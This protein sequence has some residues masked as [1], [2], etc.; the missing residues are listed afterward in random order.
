MKI[1]V[2]GA[3]AYGLALSNILSDKNEILVYSSLKEEIEKLK[4][5][6][7]FEGIKLSEKINYTSKTEKLNN[8]DIAV[9]VLP[10]Q[11]IKSELNKLKEYIKNK[12][13]IVASK[14]I[15]ENKFASE[16]VEES[17]NIESTHVLSGPSFAIDTIK[18]QP[19]VLTLAGN[20][21]SEIKNI[22]NEGY[23]KIEQTT[24]I[25]GTQI[26]GTVKNTFA[27]G[28]GILEGINA[29]T[30]TKA[31]YMTKIINETKTII[32]LF[33]GKEDT[34]MLSCG[35]GDIILTC[36]STK[37]RNFTL[38]YMKGKNENIKEYIKMQTVEGIE[39]LK[40]FSKHLNNINIEM[41]NV[42]Y[43][44]IYDNANCQEIL[45]YIIK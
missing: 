32:K 14:G 10:T 44:I 8:I 35:I 12:P 7:S 13:I 19:I 21:T 3:G 27:I 31:A 24:D 29:T 39:S 22:F 30:S 34:I 38:G 23:V 5:T 36:T 45:S 43:R 1:L 40:Y 11:F 2:V 6:K 16:L 17:L 20:N 25:I 15:Y 4:Q 41:I 28:A 9:I 37:S 26:C 42:I 18:K 33:N